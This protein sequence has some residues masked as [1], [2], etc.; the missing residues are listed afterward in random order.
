MNDKQILTQLS[1]AMMKDHL[2]ASPFKVYTFLLMFY[3]KSPSY[4]EIAS[5][6][7]MAPSTISR[8]IKQLVDLHLITITRSKTPHEPNT[9][10]LKL[11]ANR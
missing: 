4:F 5:T 7:N 11:V 1:Y 8:A 6:L 3:P 10:H 2:K 9:Y